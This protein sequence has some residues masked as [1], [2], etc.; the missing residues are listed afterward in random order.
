MARYLPFLLLSFLVLLWC[1]WVLTW[2]WQLCWQQLR[3]QFSYFYPL[4]FDFAETS[5]TINRNG[6]PVSFDAKFCLSSWVAS[7]SY[8]FWEAW[9]SYPWMLS[10]WSKLKF[11]GTLHFYNVIC[12]NLTLAFRLPC[13]TETSIFPVQ[14]L[15]SPPCPALLS[16]HFGSICLVHPLLARPSP[17]PIYKSQCL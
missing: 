16:H 14:W 9:S 5:R 17:F 2:T 4:D 11:L 6:L 8:K 15:F 10:W 7:A 12:Q 1:S 3:W 13:S